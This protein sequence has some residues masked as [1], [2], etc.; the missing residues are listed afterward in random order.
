MQILKSVI[1]DLDGTIA[2]TIPLC[3]LAFR[4]SIE[5]LINRPLSDEEIIATFGPSEEGTILALAPNQYDQGIADY[6]HFYEALHDMCPTPFAGIVDL[7][8]ALQNKHVRIAMVTGKGKYCTDLTLQKF[9]ISHFF[10]II[11]TGQPGGPRKVEG[12][13]KVL[14]YFEN[15]PKSDIVYIGDT[16]G[17]IVASKQV[18]IS[19][20]A[21][22]WAD[23][24]E[25]E[26][27]KELNP[28]GLFYQIEDLKKWLL[29]RI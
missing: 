20:L 10:E 13:Q 22:A 3:I 18:G 2:N 15:I 23:S 24:A 9:G 16:P 14:D 25:P 27:L 21:A 7:L 8:T 5:P 1:F 17:D 19:V 11:E 28:D 4:K 12:I 26:K 6:L 29:E